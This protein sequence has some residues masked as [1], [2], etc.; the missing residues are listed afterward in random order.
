MAFA[1]TH[2]HSADRETGTFKF[3]LIS[4]VLRGAELLVG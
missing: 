3:A 2:Q 4:L 1:V